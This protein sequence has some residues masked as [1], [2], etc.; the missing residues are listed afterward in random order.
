MVKD[1]MSALADWVEQKRP[2]SSFSF[3]SGRQ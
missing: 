1:G 3:V 2:I